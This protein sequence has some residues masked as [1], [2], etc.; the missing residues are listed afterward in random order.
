MRIT[1]LAVLFWKLVVAQ[2]PGTFTP[3]G[4]MSRP[5]GLHT[6]TL[7]SDG[8]VLIAGGSG[9]NSPTLASAEIYDPTSQ[10]FTATGDMTTA[11]SSHTA[12]LLLS[13]L[14]LIAGGSNRSTSLASAELYDPA[15]GTFRATGSMSAA[16]IHHTATL[17]NCGKVLIAGGIN[18]MSQTAELYD[19]STGTFTPTGDLTEPGANTATLLPNG[20]VLITRSTEFL[21]E[22]HADIYDETTGTFTRTGD[23]LDPTPGLQPAAT[24]LGNGKV[25][26]AGGSLGDLGGSTSAQLY[27]PEA[28]VF[29]STA[30]MSAGLAWAVPTLLPDGNV[31]ITGRDDNGVQCGLTCPGTAEVYDAVSGT[32]SQPL[33]AQSMETHGAT[34]LRDGTVLLTGGFQ[35]CGV[36]LA[37]AEIYHPVTLVPPPALLSLSGDGAGPGA[38]QHAGSY[39]VASADNPAFGGEILILYCTGLM[40]GNVIPP[41]VAVGG[42]AAEVLWFGN[43]P[44]FRNLNQ[45][46]IRVPRDVAVGS[47]VPVRLNYLN[48]P[49][50]EV[51]IAVR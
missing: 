44:G 27:D 34:L 49:S 46:N 28:G 1:L 33:V 32:F 23:L 31:L 47:A 48:R 41:H 18:P 25:L 24:L 6:A 19:P 26:I 10:S 8:K 15:A 7:L 4:N 37:T 35:C 30:R 16:R 43:T 40:E 21:S 22:N 11:R 3:L 29:T 12:T 20:K 45:V 38:I 14:V 13:G 50:N 36:T 5:R 9:L 2:S 42:V 17:L 39:E 51:T